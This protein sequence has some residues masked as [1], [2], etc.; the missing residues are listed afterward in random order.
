MSRW[1]AGEGSGGG[2][3]WS[4]SWG[5]GWSGS[6]GSAHGWSKG[7]RGGGGCAGWDWRGGGQGSGKGAGTGWGSGSVQGCG[8]GKGA[9]CGCGSGSDQDWRWPKR[10]RSQHQDVE[11]LPPAQPPTYPNGRPIGPHCA[12]PEPRGNVFCP[13]CHKGWNKGSASGAS[14]AADGLCP[15]CNVPVAEE[16]WSFLRNNPRA[17][18]EAKV[19]LRSVYDT[20]ETRIRE[21]T[22][23]RALPTVSM[24]AP[25][26]PLPWPAEWMHHADEIYQCG[27][28]SNP[29]PGGRPLLQTDARQWETAAGFAQGEKDWQDQQRREFADTQ[30]RINQWLAEH[31]VSRVEADP[32]QEGIRQWYAAAAAATAGSA[33]GHRESA[34]PPCSAS[35][36]EDVLF[37]CS[38]DGTFDPSEDPWEAQDTGNGLIRFL[39]DEELGRGIEHQGGRGSSTD[40]WL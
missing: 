6:K 21:R 2:G 19:L 13:R 9:G 38:S 1:G 8:W 12:W 10:Q 17:K 22:I 36:S 27:L 34:R 39:T 35:D 23:N 30:H 29:A 24:I 3:G 20:I 16:D 40:C 7:W 25:P 11:M 5:G 33:Y 15:R 14:I 4:G 18:Q 28:W 32:R 37:A 31:R 26:T